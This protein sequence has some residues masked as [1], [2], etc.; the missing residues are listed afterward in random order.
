VRISRPASF[1][2]TVGVSVLPELSRPYY[3]ADEVDTD[4]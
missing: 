4:I 1:T 3:S 2:I